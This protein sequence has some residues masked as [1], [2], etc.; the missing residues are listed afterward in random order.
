MTLDFNCQNNTNLNMGGSSVTI[1][2]DFILIRG[3]GAESIVQKN[4]G[5]ITS[6]P[7]TLAAEAKAKGKSAAA[8]GVRTEANGDASIAGG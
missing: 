6:T 2:Y 4:G 7:G 3:E 5:V 1:M 8:F